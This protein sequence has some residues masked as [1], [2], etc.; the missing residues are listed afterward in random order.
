MI[1][2]TEKQDNLTRSGR[3]QTSLPN[4]GVRIAESCYFFPF[5][6]FLV[7]QK[8]TLYC[9]YIFKKMLL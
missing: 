4:R 5:D 9:H 3:I 6:S 2:Y 7:S 8:L 1:E